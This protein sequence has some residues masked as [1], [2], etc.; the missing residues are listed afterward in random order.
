MKT[1][2]NRLRKREHIAMDALFRK[3]GVRYNRYTTKEECTY[4]LDPT[5]NAQKVTRLDNEYSYR[6]I[7]YNSS[8]D[9]VV[10]IFPRDV[11]FHEINYM[12]VSSV[13][14]SRAM[15]QTYISIIKSKEPVRVGDVLKMKEDENYFF[16][17]HK[18]FRHREHSDIYRY[19][20]SKGMKNDWWA[21]LNKCY[22]W[23]LRK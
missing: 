8:S 16:Y 5:I 23:V 14:D 4:S 12:E 15:S 7:D 21:G 11:E 13:G 6:E 20:L 18:I 3:K 17:V 9:I 1:L 10:Y 2:L 22:W 19:I